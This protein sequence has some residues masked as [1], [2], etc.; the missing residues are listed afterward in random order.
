[1]ILNGSSINATFGTM[2][3]SPIF[4][5]VLNMTTFTVSFEKFYNSSKTVV[6][7]FFATLIQNVAPNQ[8]ITMPLS[9]QYTSTP[10]GDPLIGR[11]HFNTTSPAVATS[12]VAYN[13]KWHSIA[14]FQ[15]YNTSLPE[16]SGNQT[17]NGEVIFYRIN[18]TLAETNANCSVVFTYPT[19]LVYRTS[20][21]LF[22]GSAINGTNL[23]VGS[24]AT[25][26][27]QT[28][29]FNFGLISNMAD[30]NVTVDDMIFFEISFQ[31]DDAT[32]D[33]TVLQVNAAVNSINSMS[34]NTNTTIMVV[35]PALVVQSL[36]YFSYNTEP[37]DAGDL[38]SYYTTVAYTSAR[39]SSAY[40]IVL[41][42]DLPRF[43]EVISVTNGSLASNVTISSNLSQ[44]TWRT[45]RVSNTDQYFRANFT[46]R[47]LNT[48]FANAQSVQAIATVFYDT[49]R[50]MLYDLPGTA[51][52]ATLTSASVT[53][54]TPSVL[55]TDT[56][57]SLASTIT[58]NTG[59]EEA[60]TMTLLVTVP[61]V[62]T[63]ISVQLVVPA[64]FNQMQ[65]FE[66]VIFVGSNLNCSASG[67]FTSLSNLT[68]VKSIATFDFGVCKNAYDN[69]KNTTSDQ[70]RIKVGSMMWN[71]TTLALLTSNVTLTYGNNAY[72]SPAATKFNQLT[73]R[74][75]EP[76]V[77]TTVLP[78]FTMVPQ[79]AGDKVCLFVGIY[80]CVCVCVCVCFQMKEACACVRKDLI[81]HFQNPVSD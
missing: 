5:T 4:I 14:S 71:S 47:V 17:N 23:T 16:T 61:E 53:L 66:S 41:Q 38:I 27:G 62:T 12:S 22:I 28:A 33:G 36:P 32:L 77:I 70:I 79:D 30:N 49:H 43:L 65:L 42:L 13:V 81:V 54:D 72:V 68:S 26:N 15:L 31:V 37:I 63:R 51:M 59:V 2:N 48:V 50:G 18:V 8:S 45:D 39:T 55:I 9:V 19:N 34:V 73:L 1:M 3:E 74:A 60:L 57:S 44:I 29:N 20:Q 78:S 76:N 58:P 80:V 52:S 56:G 75:T 11:F 67:V 64:N 69:V 21:I 24:A 46:V 6:F 7:K 10:T 40:D 35:R 25:I